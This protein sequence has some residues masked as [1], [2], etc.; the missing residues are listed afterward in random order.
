MTKEIIL[1][2]RKQIDGVDVQ[3][4]QIDRRIETIVL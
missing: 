4:R 3:I 2:P 1:W